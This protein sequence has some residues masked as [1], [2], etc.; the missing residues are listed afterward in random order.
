MISACLVGLA[1]P[2]SDERAGGRRV[3][4]GERQRVTHP[5]AGHG[6]KKALL[7]WPRPCPLGP[8]PLPPCEE[9]SPLSGGEEEL[10][11]REGS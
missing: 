7:P 10:Q 5:Q 9:L 2:S 4:G 11:E 3:S 8:G 6:G 1:Q